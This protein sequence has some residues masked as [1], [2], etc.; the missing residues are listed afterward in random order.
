MLRQRKT[1]CCR[2][3]GKP[4]IQAERNKDQTSNAQ[5]ADK[6]DFHCGTVQCPLLA[7]VPFART[8]F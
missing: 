6:T 7:C 3:A 4:A 1:R 8:G 5:V 2:A